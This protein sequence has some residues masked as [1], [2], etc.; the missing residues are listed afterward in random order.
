MKPRF[1]LAILLLPVAA[2]PAGAAEEYRGKP[3]GAWVA[4]LNDDDLR[5][6]WH[7]TYALGQI[8]PGAAEAVE[9]LAAM[10]ADKYGHEYVRSGA[11]WA[12]GRIGPAA[13]PAVPRLV[14]TLRSQPPPVVSVRRTVPQALGRIGP[15]ARPAVPELL[16]LLDDEDRAVR[17]NAAAALW[18]I[19]EHER[20][21]P[22]LVAML[23]TGTGTLPYKAAVALG[24]LGAPQKGDAA[25]FRAEES[26]VPF[27]EVIP[28]LIESLGHA[29]DDVRRAAGRSLG[30]LGPTT[31]PALRQALD[32]AQAPVRRHAVVALGWIGEPAVP[33]LIEALKN[34]LP[35]VRL[36]AARE[37]GRLGPAAAEARGALIEAV[38][39]PD[40]QVRA[41]AAKALSSLVVR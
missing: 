1:T 19:A 7:A 12:L 4:R 27:F 29:D 16:K 10:V 24:K 26:R 32:H 22:A 9:P 6:R 2:V 8:G 17:V 38:D 20:A 33:A 23:R 5:A 21:I 18:R 36:T 39:D 13:E 40:P 41:A 15:A 30:Q 11:A 3:A 14:E 37:L 28:A 35:P 34:D 31:I 25:L